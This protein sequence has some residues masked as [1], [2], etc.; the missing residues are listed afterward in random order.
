MELITYQRTIH[1]TQQ[2]IF[3]DFYILPDDWTRASF[4]IVFL[5]EWGSSKSK[6]YVTLKHHHKHK[7]CVWLVQRV[8]IS[9]S[10]ELCNGM[11][12]F[13]LAHR[14]HNAF[15]ILVWLSYYCCI[16]HADRCLQLRGVCKV[17]HADI[18]PET[19]V[20]G[21]DVCGSSYTRQTYA[22]IVLV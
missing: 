6:I 14:L 4:H 11:S 13:I 7:A 8:L 19:A 20:P 15:S 21:I 10:Y 3:H 1:Q 12:D 17:W 18:S 5:R 9:S 16:I 2:S 22:K